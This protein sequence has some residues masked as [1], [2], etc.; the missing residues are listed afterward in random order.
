M[1]NDSVSLAYLLSELHLASFTGRLH[2]QQN[3]LVRSILIHNGSPVHVL[4]QLQE[5]TL[6]RILLDEGTI[7][8]EQYN[9]ILRAMVETQMPTGELLIAKGYLGPQEVF[10]ALEFQVRKK[11]SNCFKMVSFKYELQEEPVQ[12]EMMITKLEV[13]EVVLTGVLTTY[14][15]DRLLNEFPVD[16]DSM[17]KLQ[18]R[19]EDMQM[20]IGPMENKILRALG[21]GT[22]LAKLM[23]SGFDL[24]YLLTVLYVFHT[25]RV[26]EAS[27]I[28]RPQI[29]LRL[30]KKADRPK[31][32][33]QQ[34]EVE[35]E[36]RVEE[37]FRPPTMASIMAGQIESKLAK[38]ILALPRQN[39]FE[40]LEISQKASAR[41][42]KRA[43]N[44]LAKK[45]KLEKIDQFYKS[46]KEQEIAGR[47]LDRATLAQ[48]VLS[49]DKSRQEYL[50]SLNQADH[51]NHKTS[52][53][54]LADVEAQKGDLALRTKRWQEARNLFDK[55]IEL[56]PNEPS[57]HFQLGKVGYL[58]VLE[59]TPQEKQ[60][61][62]SIRLP[63]LKAL[64]LDPQYDLPRLFL[65]Y[66]AKRNGNFDRAIKEFVGALEC[67]PKNRIAQSELKM[68]K[69]R[70]KK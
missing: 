45:F 15:V 19:P 1:K 64:A 60:L 23:A 54:I 12:P 7:T 49:D 26:I 4:S 67:N 20:P 42:L 16:E 57:Y 56:Y 44:R 40:V 27:G 13:L 31:I 25:L 61:P 66:L 58:Q 3:D 18:K 70:I 32:A 48:S 8:I 17:F 51:A 2:L 59:E 46:S 11:L 68:L 50:D 6:G 41:E 62:E 63:F 21:T 9:T 10:S 14:S 36:K 47:L 34:V 52:P 39:H 30:P 24:Q 22:T 43:F 65:G 55:A 5:E 53:R 37:D 35:N 69:R 33:P 29:G 38:K 28:T